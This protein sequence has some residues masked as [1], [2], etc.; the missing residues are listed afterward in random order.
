MLRRHEPLPVLL[1]VLSVLGLLSAAC[2]AG[3][4]GSAQRGEDDTAR[5]VV[6]VAH[7]PSLLFAPLY[8]ADAKGYFRQEGID[9]RMRKVKAGQDVAPLAAYGEVDMVAAG[10]SAALFDGVSEGLKVKVAASMGAS[11]GEKPSPTALEVSRSLKR[12]GE[13]EKPSD[14]RGRRVAVAGGAGSAGGYQLD[15]ILRKSG[16]TLKDVKV[17]DVPFTGM[18][19]ALAEGRTDAALSPAPFTTAMER[20]DVADQL[21]VPPEGTVATGLIA[22]QDFVPRPVAQQFLTALRKG[23]AD[24]QGDGRTSRANLTILARA[25]GQDTGLLRRTPAYRWD[26]GLRTDTRQLSKQQTAYREAGLLSGRHV[27]VDDLLP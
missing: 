11:T 16:L 5:T 9:V 3:G 15:V 21:A 25:T 26:P 4:G 10:F 19:A 12:S 6:D 14:L 24:L 23:A 20:A 17:V 18:R 7:V 22:G 1:S 27:P 2:A 13:V 8:L